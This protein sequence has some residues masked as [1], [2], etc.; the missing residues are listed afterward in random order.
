MSDAFQTVRS[1]YDRIGESYR[2]WSRNSPVRLRWVQRLLTQLSPGS[3]VVDLGCGSGEPATRLLTEH[4]RVC[5]VDASSV[6]LQ[7]A[8][9]AAPGALLVHADMTRF[10]LRPGSVDAVVSFFALGHVSSDRHA[11][12]F[13]S[14]ATW[15]RP[16]GLLMTSAPLTTED[17][18]V[19]EW[20]GVPMF[21]GGIGPA[22]T[23]AAVEGAGLAIETWE[24]D[25]EDEGG[26][27]RVEFLWLTAR[28]P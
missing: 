28:K 11:A 24:I 18:P 14:I 21:F 10:S 1:G 9:R 20:L 23:R 4:H 22:A 3:L 17:G 15:L 8:A 19:D 2:E 27:R 7:L 5:G 26:G 12:L 6:Q 13:E 25:G 16:G